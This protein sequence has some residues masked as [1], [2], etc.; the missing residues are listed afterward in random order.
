VKQ[1][2]QLVLLG[3][4]G[5]IG[6]QTLEVIDYLAEEWQVLA[7]SA[8]K[9]I[10]LLIKQARKYHPLFLVIMHEKLAKE[11]KYRL[12]DL[13]ID[14]LVGMDGLEYISSL[15]DADL[16]IN[17][18][19]GAAGLKPSISTLKAG[20]RL[21]LAN[22][23]SLVIGGEI[24]NRLLKQNNDF[25]LPIDSEH[26]T[27]FQILSGHQGDEVKNI[28]LTASG[29]PFL[30]LPFEQMKDVS[31]KQALKH[32]RWNMGHRISI[33][34]ATLMNKGLE[35]IEA[36]WLYHQSYDKIKVIIHP[37]SIIHS[38]VEF[39]D[40]SITAELSIADMR[41]FIQNVLTYPVKKSGLIR[42]LDLIETGQLTFRKPD[43]ERF[44]ALKLAYDAGREGGSSP[45]VL[46]AANEVA[47]EGFIKQKISFTEIPEIV[48]RTLQNHKIIKNPDLETIYEIDNWSR[49]K[50][51]E[52][53]RNC[54]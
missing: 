1:V 53:L 7:L 33:D 27:I 3:S 50:A 22:K 45:V 47:I 15:S 39:I 37:E 35:V 4:T 48:D 31:V 2:K 52:V 17:A 44:P 24:I 51:E 14:I 32:P 46:N 18:L 41:L 25:I 54:Y 6:T 29:G 5:S 34:S 38:M 11:L 42:N 26:H 13:N 16:V 10:D 49:R 12:A 8:N 19:V 9:N 28:I 40:K 43:L 36:H 21:G 30:D 23:E 20:N